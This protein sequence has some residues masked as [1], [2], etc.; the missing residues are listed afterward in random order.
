VNVSSP[1][2]GVVVDVLAAEG[3]PVIDGAPVLVVE[4]MKMHHEVF[5]TATGVVGQVAVEVGDRVAEGQAV[6]SI[7]PGEPEGAVAPAAETAPKGS[8]MRPDLAAALERRRAITDEA[9]PDAVSRRRDTG[10]PTARENVAALC[11][12]RTFSEYGGLVIAAQRARRS[13]DDLIA[14][15]PGDGIVTGIGVVNGHLFGPDARC[16]VLAY[17]YTVLA[18]TQ[19][20][21]GHRKADRMIELAAELELPIV[22]FAEGGGGRP[23]DT[24][25]S[26]LFHLDVPTFHGFAAL[27]GLVPRIGVV[28]GRCFAG[29]AA[30]LGCC[31]VMI[32]TP[33]ATLGMGGPAMIEGGGLGTFEPEDIGPVDVLEP[34]GVVDVVASDHAE[35]VATAR[36]CLAYFQGAVAEWTCA[37][38]AAL[39]SAIP[40]DP[41][42]SH[43]VR[44]L[45]ALLADDDSVLE[46]RPRFG[47]TIVTALA[48]V[49]GRPVGILANDPRRR[50]GAIDSDGS[51]KGA[52]FVQ[53]CDAFGLPIVSLIDTPGF[54]V[55]P[56]SEAEAAVRHCSRLFIAGSTASIP[57]ISVV[58]RRA[59]GLGAQAMTGGGF[60]VPALNIAWPSGEFGAM[61]VE[62]AVKLALR[63]ELEAIDDEDKRDRRVAEVAT[64]IREQSGALNMAAH[65]EIDDVID[66]AETRDRIVATLRAI[67]SPEP[68][69]RRTMIDSW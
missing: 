26:E 34:N 23:G 4:S 14:N 24:D 29:N 18:G 13:V 47:R 22:L 3:Q 65:F 5:A 48:R 53:L 7:E 51:D 9:R 59:F 40:E 68:G 62:G 42:R 31:D 17:D 8:E 58:V 19:G 28:S 27:S 12:P 10:L 64:S 38:Q 2:A 54:M 63:R 15:T 60:H 1:L 37:D 33:D 21:R 11:D 39:R 66:P 30:L 36:R 46:L 16:A 44:A 55:G 45:I 61:G 20:V 41:K 57:F 49:E 32:A 67:P 6:L 43:D 69:R 25:R 52:R 56:E 50:S 35:A